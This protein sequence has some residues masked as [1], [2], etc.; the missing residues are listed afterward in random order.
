MAAQ[1]LVS[2]SSLTFSAE[3]AKQSFGARSHQSPIG[4]SRKGSFIVKAASTPPVKVCPSLTICL[5]EHTCVLIYISIKKKNLFLFW[6]SA[7]SR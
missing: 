1:A 2:S 3:A 6:S 4:F 7:R 5:I